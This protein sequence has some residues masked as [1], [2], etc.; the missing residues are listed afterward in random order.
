MLVEDTAGIATLLGCRRPSLRARRRAEIRT[1]GWALLIKANSHACDARHFS[2]WGRK[3]RLSMPRTLTCKPPSSL[4]RVSFI[5]P[6]TLITSTNFAVFFVNLLEHI[7]LCL[8]I[9]SWTMSSSS[10]LSMSY[11]PARLANRTS[12]EVQRASSS[13]KYLGIDCGSKCLNQQAR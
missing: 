4:L 1:N 7:K 13:L 6:L 8:Q 11:I 5:V 10:L 2:L 9:L 3:P 12:Q